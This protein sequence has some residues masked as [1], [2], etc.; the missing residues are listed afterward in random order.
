M[1]QLEKRARKLSKDYFPGLNPKDKALLDREVITFMMVEQ[2]SLFN[3]FVSVTTT[4]KDYYD[5]L[6]VGSDT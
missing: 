3:A 2:V 6:C 4:K 5:T 1:N